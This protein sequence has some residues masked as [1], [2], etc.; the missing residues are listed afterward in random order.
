MAWNNNNVIEF[1]N[2]NGNKIYAVDPSHPGVVARYNKTI[3]THM[4]QGCDLIRMDFTYAG[5]LEGKLDK[6]S[7][8]ILV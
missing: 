4:G 8:F 1:R 2:D 6:K 5:F 3:G 7:Q